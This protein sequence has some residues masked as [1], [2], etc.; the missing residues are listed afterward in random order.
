[1]LSYDIIVKAQPVFLHYALQCSCVTLYILQGQPRS[2]LDPGYWIKLNPNN[3]RV[4]TN[5]FI[6]CCPITSF[7]DVSMF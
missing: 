3:L 6:H 7:I 1:M 4:E 2:S 5:V